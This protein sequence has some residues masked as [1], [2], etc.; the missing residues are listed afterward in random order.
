LSAKHPNEILI[1]RLLQVNKD[2]VELVSNLK[3]TI[4]LL[5]T[6]RIFQEQGVQQAVRPN[7]NDLNLAG[8]EPRFPSMSAEEEDLRWQR[9]QG[10]IDNDELKRILEQVGL[11]N[12]DVTFN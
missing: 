3:T 4:I 2:L 8:T 9:D 10:I 12:S 7:P 6:P 5:T 11:D 1:E